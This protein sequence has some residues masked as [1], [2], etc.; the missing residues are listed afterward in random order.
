MLATMAGVNEQPPTSRR[1]KAEATRRRILTAAQGLLAE[2]GYAGT[3]MQAIADV[4]GVAVQT[5]YFVF[6]TKGELVRQLLLALGADAGEPVETMERDWVHEAMTDPDGHRTIALMVEHGNDIYARVVPFWPAIRQGAAT[7]P[8]IASVWEGI[9][10]QRRAG[11]RRIMTSL[12]DREHL[13][14]DVDVGRAADIMYGLQRPET[15]ATF[16]DECGWTP[17]NYK[18]WSYRLLC[19]QLLEPRL[20][21][22]LS[23]TRGLAFDPAL[24]R[25]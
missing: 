13:R 24:A 16:V 8:E 23:P 20:D 19:D 2:R 15:Y 4:A 18:A 1:E 17:E 6:H 12:A 14:S 5:V 11:I 22:D 21:A 25:R 3:T 9:V 7:E 10:Q